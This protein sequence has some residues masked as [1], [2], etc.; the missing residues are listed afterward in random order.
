MKRILLTSTALALACGGGVAAMEGGGV[1][2]TSGEA[3]LGVTYD[4]KNDGREAQFFHD[5]DFVM[6]ASG[7]S[8]DGIAFGA[9]IKVDAA[10]GN[11]RVWAGRASVTFDGM[12]TLTVGHDLD[13]A[14]TIAGGLGDPGLDGVGADDK[15]EAL[16]N[17]TNR[18]FRY[19]GTFGFTTI[20]VSLGDVDETGGDEAWAFGAS[21][22]LN[23]IRAGIG[24]NS[25]EVIS[26]GANITQGVVSAAMY[27]ALDDDT[28]GSAA[29]KP[30]GNSGG[31]EV[32]Y[33]MSD[34][35]SFQLVAGQSDMN[36]MKE[37]SFGGGF[38]HDLGG[39]ATLKGGI[40]TY[41][42]GSTDYIKAD[43]G[44]AMKF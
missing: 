11:N 30:E 32:G 20:A 18:D 35:M 27:Y 43:F 39:G 2:F 15:A 28:N 13:A 40:G 4:E 31:V 36:D 44:I 37:T 38:A 6:G 8:D 24:V 7:T 33:Q 22:D 42:D 1:A 14:D 21:F 16:R 29:G 41:E 3:K 19:D 25:D 17:K 23:P 12:H 26:L 9:S 34:D 10:D 5:V